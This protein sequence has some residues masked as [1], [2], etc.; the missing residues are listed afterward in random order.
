MREPGIIIDFSK[1]SDLVLYDRLLMK[2]AVLG[3]DSRVVV[4]VSEFPLGRTQRVRVGGQLPKEVK[5]TAGVSQ[6]SVLGPLLFLAYVNDIW[7]NL[8]STVRIYADDCIMYR[9]IM[10]ERDIETLQIDLDRLGERAV[11]KAMKINSGKSKAVRF[12]R[13]QVKYPLN[14]IL[15]DQIIPET[16]SCQYLGVILSRDLSWAYRVNYTA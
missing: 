10:N 15:E 5:V 16:S 4:W 6:G 3:V 2:I 1:A 11:G 8:E 13:A 9:K 7:R 12:T 14:Y